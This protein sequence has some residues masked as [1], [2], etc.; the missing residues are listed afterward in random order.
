MLLKA[1]S[2]S[3]SIITFSA[4]F[5]PSLEAILHTV[6]SLHLSGWLRYFNSLSKISTEKTD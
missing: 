5:N 1:V 3:V 2:V 6:L 4:F